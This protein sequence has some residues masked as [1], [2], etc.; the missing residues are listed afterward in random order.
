MGKKRIFTVFWMLL[1]C[2]TSIV[3]AQENH[4]T[5]DIYKYQYDMTAFLKVELNGEVITSAADYEVAAFSG[6]DCCGVAS[7]EES[8]DYYYLRIRSNHV[9]GDVITFKCYDKVNKKEIQL[10]DTVIFEQLRVL[11]MPSEPKILKG[12]VELEPEPEPEP[13]PEPEPEPDPEPEPEPDPEPEPEP[14]PALY[15]LTFMLD[16]TEWKVTELEEGD[17]IVYPEVPDKE[18]YSFSGWDQKLTVMPAQDLTV[19]GT[20]QVNSYRIVYYLNEK[21][22]AEETLPYGTKIVLL[23]YTPVEGETFS[24]WSEVPDLMPAHDVEVYGSTVVT[25]V[26]NLSTD[27]E[28]N[29]YTLQG[30]LIQRNVTLSSLKGLL[31]KGLYIING[32]LVHWTW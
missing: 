4:W 3:T 5:C 32:K 13:D 7:Y 22:Y 6:D 25:G 20:Y 2:C 19:K 12:Q 9:N 1:L 10:T 24:G 21:V 14:E 17:E 30:I 26:V 8:L 16:G 28:V 27:I 23:E 18:G 11:G 15:K 31:R 29:V